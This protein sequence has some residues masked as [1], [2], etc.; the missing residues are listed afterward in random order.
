MALVDSTGMV[1]GVVLTRD[2]QAVPG[3]AIRRLLP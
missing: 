2:G 1:V 3:R